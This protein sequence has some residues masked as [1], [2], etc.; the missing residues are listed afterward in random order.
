MIASAID[1]NARSRSL[2][3]IDNFGDLDSQFSFDGNRSSKK[4]DKKSLAKV[5]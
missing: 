5:I 3:E 4:S 1:V 2:K